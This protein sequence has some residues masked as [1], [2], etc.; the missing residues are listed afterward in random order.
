M[1]PSEVKFYNVI[2]TFFTK[3]IKN[4]ETNYFDN[5]MWFFALP[6]LCIFNKK[7]CEN[8]GSSY[9]TKI[10]WKYVNTRMTPK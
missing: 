5:R 2:T 6:I 9:F 10:M 8:M 3:A 4:C 7:L 1:S